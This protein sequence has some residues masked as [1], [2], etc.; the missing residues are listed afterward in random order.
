MTVRAT[1]RLLLLSTLLVLLVAAVLRFYQLG[2]APPGFHYDEAVNFIVAREIAFQGARPFPVF[3]AFNGREVFYFYSAAVFMRGIGEHIFTMHV[4]SG[5]MN[6]LTVATTIGLGRA[7]FGGQR[8]WML[9]VLAAGFMAVSFPQIF[10]ARQAFRAVS[11]PL[12]QALALWAL[13]R[14]LQRRGVSWWLPLAGLLSGTVLYTYMASRLFPVWVGITLLMLLY[15]ERGQWVQ[16]LRQMLVFSA[17]FLLAAAPITRYYLDN[18]DVFNDRLNQL[19]GNTD[20]ITYA[21]SV[22]LHLR[23]FFIE[24]DP[25]IRYNEPL[26]PY[27]SAVGG[28]LLLIGLIVATIR[29]FKH[30]TPPVQR[31]AY[32][33][34]LLSPLMVLPSILALD[35][36]PPSHMRSIAMVPLVFFLPALG[37][38]GLFQ[39][40]YRHKVPFFARSQIASGFMAALFIGL[41]VWVWGRY[42][43][44]VNTPD[45]YYLNDGDMVAA[46]AWLEDNMQ[47]DA[48]VY[49]T[50]QHYDHPTLQMHDIPGDNITYLLGERLF[51]PPPTRPAYFVETA[52]TPLSSA[53]RPF[54]DT[55]DTAQSH[56]NHDGQFAFG[57]YQFTPTTRTQT[58]NRTGESVGGVL[59]L[60]EAQTTVAPAGGTLTVTSAWEIL[61][62]PPYDDF[63]PLFQLETP[64]GDVLDRVEPFMQ[65]TTRWRSGERL[66]E[67][68]RFE[69]PPGTA[70]G[71]DY[72]VRVAWV[73]RLSDQ[74]VGR[75]D[76]N[77]SFA[78]LWTD[79]ATVRVERPAEPVSPAAL[80]IPVQAAH[81]FTGVRLSGYSVL[82]ET[83]RPGEVLPLDLYWQRLNTPPT[84]DELRLVLRSAADDMTVLYDGPP[85]QGSYP[86]S[87]WQTNE[88]LIDR[89]RWRLPTQ[90]S[91]GDYTLSVEV[92]ADAVALGQLRVADLRRTFDLPANITSLDVNFGDTVRLAGY[93]LSTTTLA[94]GE[95]LD[96]TLHWQSIAPTDLPLTVFVHLA[97]P[98]GVNQAQRDVQPRQNTYPVPLWIPGEVVEDTYTLNLPSTAPPGTYPIRVG[99]YLQSTGQRLAIVD[100]TK[101][102]WILAEITVQPD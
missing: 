49:V 58:Q 81:D 78:G 97:D 16:R 30:N 23:M 27:F 99:L 74:Y 17:F 40:T 9:G 35:G 98:N 68:V 4:V 93:T 10:I 88:T 24:G 84:T 79:V 8:G 12:L 95:P 75:V 54:L 77:G 96:V 7:M 41:S 51:L 62:A 28:S 48:L 45:L 15:I 76:Q 5:L 39:A 59:R 43:T 89:H 69:I 11:L 56:D 86:F 72:R 91:A 85:V 63:T 70:P 14:G 32:L 73:G 60:V 20:S 26:A 21:E 83:M 19:S 13:F 92:G 80:D 29:L 53:L 18:P 67:V 25:F 33:L 102:F 2:S 65:R 82:P 55:F 1:N 90:L 50:S 3:A 47:P 42:D 34:A 6:L 101:D 64:Q 87:A 38:E 94:P 61:Q 66:I 57:V 22:E 46:G 36:L 37:A 100:H 31:S 52:N 44:W 71:D